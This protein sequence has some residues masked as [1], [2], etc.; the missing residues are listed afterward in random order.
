M[1]VQLH[2]YLTLA[3]D[4]GESWASRSSRFDFDAS[5]QYPLGMRMTGLEI[6]P[7]LLS[8]TSSNSTFGVDPVQN[9]VENICL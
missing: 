1:V 3:L 2:A 8:S 6:S 7:R 9:T 5:F 4:R